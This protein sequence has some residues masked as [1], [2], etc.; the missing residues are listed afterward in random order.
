MLTYY[1]YKLIFHG[2]SLPEDLDLKQI[3]LQDPQPPY[4]TEAG[5]VIRQDGTPWAST[6]IMF[7][8]RGA[9]LRLSKWEGT[10]Q[11]SLSITYRTVEPHGLL[12][13]NGGN[14]GLRDF[15][16]IEIFDGIPYFVIDLGDAVQRYP[17]TSVP[18]K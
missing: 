1:Y 10:T 17:F 15:V 2:S 18:K 5:E 13:Y 3:F 8:R 12:L 9:Y 14:P 7:K 6:S 4:V 11:N 16:A